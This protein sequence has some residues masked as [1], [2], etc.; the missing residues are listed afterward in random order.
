MVGL[1]RRWWFYP[2]VLIPGGIIGGSWWLTEPLVDRAPAGPT[3]SATGPVVAVPEAAAAAARV[4]APPAWPKDRLEGAEAKRLLRD[5]LVHVAD[6]LNG[7]D[8]YTATFYKQ[9]RIKGKLGPRHRLTLKVR[10]KP[11]AVYLKF[12]EPQAGKEV[13]YA[14]GHHENKVIAHSG[15]LS[16]LLVPRLALPPDHPMATADSRH[17]ITEAGVANLTAK[18]LRFRQM[19]LEDE[20]AQTV[21][22]RVNDASGRP[23]LRSI[24]SHTAQHDA[25]PFAR[26]EVLY[27]PDTYLPVDIRSF[28]WPAPGH[29]GDLLLAEHYTYEDIRFDAELSAIDF[30]PANPSYAFHRY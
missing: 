29:E 24:H 21:L 25:R 20:G 12:L 19:D 8:G 26:V 27:D 16:R 5:A 23:R 15:G 10:H 3:P 28:D 22:D 13:V 2:V 9:E 18:L 6:R 17:P 11:F 7:I 14:E 30:D 1:F 4:D